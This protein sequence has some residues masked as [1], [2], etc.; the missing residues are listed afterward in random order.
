MPSI[1]N[2]TSFQS[3][4]E[5]YSLVRP[6]KVSLWNQL[7]EGVKFKRSRLRL[8]LYFSST[9]DAV[10]KLNER[11][12]CHRRAMPRKGSVQAWVS[13]TPGSLPW[14]GKRQA[15]PSKTSGFMGWILHPWHSFRHNLLQPRNSSYQ[16][17]RIEMAWSL[18]PIRDVFRVCISLLVWVRAKP[19]S[20]FAISTPY[21]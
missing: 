14:S 18:Q 6:A 21:F 8:T 5:I 2:I 1:N 4:I 7:W 10:P 20:R 9:C 19:H 15:F 16:P 3:A 12:N 17:D 13:F 11:Y